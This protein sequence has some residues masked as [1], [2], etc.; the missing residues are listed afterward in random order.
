[1]SNSSGNKNQK[2]PALRIA[3]SFIAGELKTRNYV[4]WKWEMHG[5]LKGRKT[6]KSRLGSEEEEEVDLVGTLCA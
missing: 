4:E 3:V 1:M 5:W 2:L 6:I